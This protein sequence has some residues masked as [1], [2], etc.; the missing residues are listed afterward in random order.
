MYLRLHAVAWMLVSLF[1]MAADAGAQ[2][3]WPSKPIRLILQSPPGGT[4]D[5]IAR[6]LQAP[7]QE[8]LGQPVI[9]DSRPGSFGVVAGI[10]VV[11]SGADGHTFGLFGSSLA[12]NVVTQKNLP[13]DALR[14]FTAV[15]LVAQA[16]SIIAVNASTP[17][18]TLKDLVAAA[19]AK[20]GSLSFGSSGIGLAPHFAVEWLKYRAGIDMVHVPYKGAGPAINAAIGGEIPVVVTVAGSATPHIQGG[21]LRPLAVSGAERLPLLPNVPTVAEQGYP[22]FSIIDW[23]GVVGPAGI[24][25]DVARRM[26]AE[27]NRA[28]RIPAI[29][30]RLRALGFQLGSQS[31]E[32][33]QA[34][35]QSEV[36]SLGTIIR[37]AKISVE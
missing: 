28:L 35:I 30:D 13:Y 3:S 9:V 11:N 14:D 29:A 34:F 23:F 10:A 4:S 33:F 17:Y 15:A 19:K 22:D 7:L 5:L 6:F 16:P 32:E 31:P 12:T 20:P 37:E 24:P 26:N 2:A 27:I 25:A 8:A 18:H 1:A 21:R 36:R